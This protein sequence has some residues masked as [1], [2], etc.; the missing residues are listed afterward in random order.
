MGVI[1]VRGCDDDDDDEARPDVASS[2]VIG[3]GTFWVPEKDSCSL[4]SNVVELEPE[5]KDP[6]DAEG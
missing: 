2:D 6:Q 5:G 3:I 4:F 1:K